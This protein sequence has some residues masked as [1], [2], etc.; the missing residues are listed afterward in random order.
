M[1][2]KNSINTF[3]TGMT[4]D[5]DVLHTPATAYRDSMNGRLIYNKNGTYSWETENGGKT[6]I[7]I[8]PRGGLDNST[9][10]V[11]GNA[12]NDNIVV[13]FLVREDEGA[14]EIGLLSIDEF[15]VGSYKTLF[16]D[17]DD[18]NGDSL[19][20]TIKNQIEARF[21]Y[22]NDSLIR[23]YW[24]DGVHLDSNR[25]RTITFQY[26][27]NIGNPSDVNAYSSNS[28]SVFAMDSQSDF[29]TQ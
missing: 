12:G 5:S 9:Y 25:P 28:P 6:S 27:P 8:E 13:L 14:S 21:V 16:N 20:F 26:D 1:Q 22:E 4:Q 18:P 23:T 19:N 15:G 2:G 17:Q 29:H 10:Y 3:G 11:T 7:V 24:V